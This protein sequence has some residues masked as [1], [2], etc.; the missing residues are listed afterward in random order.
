MKKFLT[1]LLIVASIMLYGV[2]MADAPVISNETLLAYA[3]DMLLG[4]GI[5]KPCYRFDLSANAA[6]TA[7]IYVDDGTY[8]YLNTCQIDGQK[9]DGLPV[10]AGTVT[11]NWSAV[12]EN[13]NHHHQTHHE[14]NAPYAS[15]TYFLVIEVAN[16][17]G[18]AKSEHSFTL[19]TNLHDLSEKVWYPSNTVCSFGPEFKEAIP[20]VTDA[21]YTFSAAD[22]SVQGVQTFDLVAAG[23]WHL[24]T[25]TVTVNG[26]TVVVDYLCT[27]D[28]N[29]KD[30][31]DEIFVEREWFTIFGD[32]ASVTTVVPEEINTSFEFGK[33]I[34]IAKDLGGDTNVLLYVNN[35]M[36]YGHHNPYVVRFWPNLPENKAIVEAMYALLAD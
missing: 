17:N 33:P 9:A 14:T 28:I 29:T 27:E 35:V 15:A 6:I 8:T 4:P 19:I 12:D 18:T 22:L 25:V 13:G 36:T 24:G 11:L 20:G 23:A 34:S 21:W 26:D 32:L 30:I 10:S 5:W 1:L 3:P 7:K 31:W 16:A 2:A